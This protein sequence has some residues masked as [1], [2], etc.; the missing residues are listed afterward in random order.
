MKH[1]DLIKTNRSYISFIMLVVSLGLIANAQGLTHTIS[2]P[3]LA[4]SNLT[5]PQNVSVY[6]PI[7]VSFN[8]AN[9]GLV[10]SNNIL[11]SIMI[12][13][14]SNSSISFYTTSLS[15]GQNESVSAYLSNATGTTGVYYVYV[16]A[17]YIVNGTKYRTGS[18]S[19]YLVSY[20]KLAAPPPSN[21]S[22]STIP[23]L[24]ITYLPILNYLPTNTNLL[25]QISITNTASNSL[26]V[27]FS[28]PSTFSN[29]L[30]FSIH[31]LLI[32]PTQSLISSLAFRPGFG[33]QPSAYVIPVKI[34]RTGPNN[35]QASQTEYLRFYTISIPPGLTG[36]YNNA[37]LS[38]NTESA[39]GFII[40][41]SSISQALN[42]TTVRLLL[43]AS[44]AKNISQL[45]SY[46]GA[47][48]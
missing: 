43:N 37:Y 44:V 47:P 20:S 16:N 45:S 17:S 18:G 14:P 19:Q 10:A 1:P 30:T 32:S 8:I 12:N 28:V 39:S 31:L 26:S 6:S 42:S 29:T 2:T 13:G 38:N 40:V 11:V 22:T 33:T 21:I 27:N 4:I 5:V 36:L 3:Y 25:S 7:P 48:T 24:N 34:A 9:T 23:Y 46:G 15:A 41:Y 35:E